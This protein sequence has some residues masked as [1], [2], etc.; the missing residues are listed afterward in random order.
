MSFFI[1]FFFHFSLLFRTRFINKYCNQQK[2]RFLF[3]LYLIFFFFF[4]Y[5]IKFSFTFHLN[6]EFFYTFFSFFLNYLEQFITKF[7]T[8][9]NID[10]FLF[11][12]YLFFKHHSFIIYYLEPDSLPN[13]V[14]NKNIASCGNLATTTAYKKGYFLDS[15][16]F[17]ANF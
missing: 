6:F 17:I 13:L 16:Y 12:S 3:Y 9:R 8:N 2:Y 11:I 15:D 1:L 7:I 5:S 10:F 4:D 14:T